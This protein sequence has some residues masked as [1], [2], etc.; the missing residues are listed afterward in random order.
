MS[1]DDAARA[2]ASAAGLPPY[3]ACATLWERTIRPAVIGSACH[4]A[5]SRASSHPREPRRHSTTSATGRPLAIWPRASTVVA[6]MPDPAFM[7]RIVLAGCGMSVISL[8]VVGG[9]DISRQR[10]SAQGRMPWRSP[11]GSGV[12]VSPCPR[13]ARGVPGW[14]M[15]AAVILAISLMAPNV[16]ADDG[17]RDK[18][19]VLNNQG[20]G[21]YD[22][23]N[24]ERA[25]DLFAQAYQTYPDPRILFNLGQ[26]YRK[27]RN[28][29][30]ALE[31]YRAYLRNMQEAPN[32]PAVEALIGELEAIAEKQR[33]SDEKPPQ[34]T[35]LTPG[36]S[37]DDA[38]AMAAANF[39][40]ISKVTEP[41]PWYS[42]TSGWWLT[43]GGALAIGS[44]VGLFISTSSL[45]DKLAKSPEDER[46][47]IRTDISTRRTFGAL[48]AT[49][50]GLAVAGGILVF[51]VSPR[52]ATREIVPLKDLKLSVAPNSITL[53][54][55][56]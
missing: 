42:N 39:K 12:C 29:E 15:S 3:M 27:T 54:R 51:V 16:R 30:R 2:R 11:R 25:I 14:F 48:L 21:A 43:G 37:A 53:S 8:S 49:V 44:G 18:A 5:L 26:S 32:R 31:V 36:G 33:A 34:G 41:R 47:G 10:G 20:N 23:G 9:L 6:R 24:Y 35:R 28:Y 13:V 22:V 17:V 4:A 56:F 45:E 1:V 38:S 50:G 46:P 55:D 19:R 52:T 7:A 40:Y